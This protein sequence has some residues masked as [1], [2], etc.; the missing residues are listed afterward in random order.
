MMKNVTV[1]LPSGVARWARVWAAEH[2]T[3]VS[4]M[5]G[6]LLRSRMEKERGYE[7]AAQSYLQRQPQALKR[8]A[9]AYPTRDEIHER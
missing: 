6:D 9:E 4:R 8:P 3:S 5:L 2:D 7:S 1:S